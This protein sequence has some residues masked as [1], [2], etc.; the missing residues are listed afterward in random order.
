MTRR[1]HGAPDFVDCLDE[2]GDN[3]FCGANKAVLERLV[4]GMCE[5][6]LETPVIKAAEDAILHYHSFSTSCVK[7]AIPCPCCVLVRASSESM[8][9]V[10]AIRRL[11]IDD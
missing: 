4:N 1:F 11:H 9:S 10:A 7:A 2:G 6:I 5:D 8:Q 3:K